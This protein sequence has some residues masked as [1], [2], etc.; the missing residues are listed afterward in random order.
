MRWMKGSCRSGSQVSTRYC[1]AVMFAVGAR[2]THEHRNMT[3]A[4]RCGEL[5]QQLAEAIASSQWMRCT[6]HTLHAAAEVS[7]CSC[8]ETMV[9]A[10][11]RSWRDEAGPV[12]S[13]VLP[14]RPCEA[15]R[16][17][18]EDL[19]S[20]L[21][22]LGGWLVCYRP[23]CTAA[24]CQ[25][26]RPNVQCTRRPGDCGSAEALVARLA[27]SGCKLDH[28]K[29][30]TSRVAFQTSTG[31][32]KCITSRANERSDW[33]PGPMECNVFNDGAPE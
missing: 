27:S 14:R 1:L 23:P 12:D 19:D 18:I 5:G 9:H 4:D 15:R 26:L 31:L 25:K 29:P 11:G 8:G 13:N 32:P 7:V 30:H 20:L 17:A 3:M 16:R 28:R 6:C 24:G 21:V 10:R 2:G 33:P 22:K